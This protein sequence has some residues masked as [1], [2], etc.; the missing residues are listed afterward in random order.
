[1]SDLSGGSFG[2]NS[3]RGG[4]VSHKPSRVK[5]GIK[6]ERVH[7]NKG[8]AM[9]FLQRI[10]P[11]NW[12]DIICCTLILIFVIVVA[13]NWQVFSDWLFHTI[14]FPVISIGS[15]LLALVASI[16]AAV[17]AIGLWFRRKRRRWWW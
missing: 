11:E 1:M 14:L 12:V 7:R 16:A 5:K 4:G 13:C 2:S 6:E 3:N 17:G 10:S 8:S 9:D 15:K